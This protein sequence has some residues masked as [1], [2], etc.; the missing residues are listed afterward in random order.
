MITTNAQAREF[1]STWSAGTPAPVLRAW[2]RQ[3]VTSAAGA[4]PV[5][6]SRALVILQGL[7]DVLG[8]PLV[9]CD[10]IR[11]WAAPDCEHPDPVCTTCGA[12]WRVDKPSTE[13]PGPT[14]QRT[15]LP[16]NT[17]QPDNA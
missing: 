1:A 7:S 14:R 15:D 5:G 4:G 9:I 10:Q 17:Y 8:L 13:P 2:V 3:F 16:R 6:P 12:K 11:Q